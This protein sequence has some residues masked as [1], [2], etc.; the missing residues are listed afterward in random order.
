MCDQVKTK[1][2][3]SLLL[4]FLFVAPATADDDSYLQALEAEAESSS[5]F[6]K[7]T[8][9]SGADKK[10]SIADQEGSRLNQK[11]RH[12][13]FNRTLSKEL[14]ATTRAYNKLT[15]EN[16][17][18]VVDAYFANKKNMSVATRLLFNL[19]FKQKTSN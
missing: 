16:K 4:F 8:Q 17:Q 9:P 7:N 2:F 6:K 5:N 14:P 12:D 3:Y 15:D 13:E 19:Y 10:Q 11:I 18:K 1:L